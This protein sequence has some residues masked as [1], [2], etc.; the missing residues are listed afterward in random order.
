MAQKKGKITTYDE[1]NEEVIV[2]IKKRKINGL[3]SAIGRL[4]T[5]YNHQDPDI[6][7]LLAQVSKGAFS[8]FTDLKHHR[9]ENNNL[10]KYSTKDWSKSDKEKFSRQLKELRTNNIVRVYTLQITIQCLSLRA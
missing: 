7:D 5:V 6:F 8:L 2:R 3:F 10:V 1:D 9:N 4:S